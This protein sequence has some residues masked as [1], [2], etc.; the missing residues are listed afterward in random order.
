[1]VVE[2]QFTTQS[3]DCS[4]LKVI[5]YIIRARVLNPQHRSQ[6]WC[7]TVLVFITPYRYWCLNMF[8]LDM[9]HLWWRNLLLDSVINYFTN[10]ILYLSSFTYKTLYGN[11]I[12]FID[13]GMAKVTYF[14]Y[15]GEIHRSYTGLSEYLGLFF[16][17]RC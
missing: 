11:F 8:N 15:F 2:T 14:G 16:K 6:V 3:A 13:I 17:I 9:P 1:M 4:K 7:V 12:R 10:I 5:I